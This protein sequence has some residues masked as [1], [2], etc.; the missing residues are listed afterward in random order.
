MRIVGSVPARTTWRPAVS[1]A[2]RPKVEQLVELGVHPGEA[3]AAELL[4]VEVELE[5]ERADLGRVRVI[6]ER[7]EHRQRSGRRLPRSVDEEHLLLG[8]DA[9]DAGLEAVV[10]E[11]HLQRLQVAEHPAD[12]RLSIGSSGRRLLAHQSTNSSR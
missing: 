6:G 12:R 7:G 1:A 10:G 9:P 11:H 4:G 8:A 5:V 2:T 3:V